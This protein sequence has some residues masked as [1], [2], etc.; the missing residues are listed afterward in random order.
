MQQLHDVEKQMMKTG[1]LFKGFF[2]VI[3]RGSDG[4]VKWKEFCQNLVV[5]E[6][7]NH[8]LDV[9]FHAD[10]PVDPWYVGLKLTGSPA[11]G[12][13]LPSHGG[14]TEATG[15]AEDRKEYIEAAASGQSIT[16]AASKATFA[17]SSTATIDG[18]FVA[19]V[20]AGT[21]GVLMC[22]ADFAS[23][24]GVSSGD[25]LEVTYAISAADD[26]A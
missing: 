1:A 11:A 10:T 23:A 4:Q 26:G 15:Y 8:I 25:T 18:A 9:I 24:K 6:G 22:A 14:W 19:A 17:I 7:L 13:T 21:G 12:D 16:N 5:N 2:E 20:S 3:C